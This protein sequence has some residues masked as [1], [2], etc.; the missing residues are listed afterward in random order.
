MR[1]PPR[2]HGTLMTLLAAA[3]V[4]CGSSAFG[5]IERQQLSQARSRW[6]AAGVTAYRVD[7]RTSCFCLSALPE[8]TTIEVRDDRVV[9]AELPDLDDPTLE[10]PLEEWPTVAGIFAQ[11]EGASE[12]DD[13]SSIDAAYHPDLGYPTRV[14]LSCPADVLDCGY[15]VELRNLEPLAPT[16]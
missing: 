9:A 15:R 8:F 1:M 2:S 16:P 13:Y 11:I 14:E 5:P 6:E 3:S 7:V 12:L 10:I 4:G